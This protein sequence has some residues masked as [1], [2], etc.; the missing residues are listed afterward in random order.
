MGGSFAILAIYFSCIMTPKM[1]TK[2]DQWGFVIICPW[3]WWHMW[4]PFNACLSVFAIG[5]YLVSS[6]DCNLDLSI[7]QTQQK[8]QKMVRRQCCQHMWP[9]FNGCC[10]YLRLGIISR[11]HLW[12]DLH[13]MTLAPV[14]IV[15]VVV[16]VQL[17]LSPLLQKSAP[18]SI[19]V[20]AAVERQCN[21]ED[22]PPHLHPYTFSHFV[23]ST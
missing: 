23:R 10:P 22:A 11:R 13:Q 14:S 1:V 17:L 12:T 19:V 5:D 21:D 16:V 15:V 9:P 20:L 7:C 4:P 6:S 18:V 2:I 8:Y 3:S